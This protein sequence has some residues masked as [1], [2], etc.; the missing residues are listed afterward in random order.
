MIDTLWHHPKRLEWMGGGADLP[1]LHS[2]CV[3][4]RDSKIVRVAVS[5]GGMWMTRDAGATWSNDNTGMWQDHAPEEHRMNPNGQDAHRMVQCPSRLTAYGSSITT[6]SS[7]PMTAVRCG[8]E[9]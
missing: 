1:G 2:I 5:T 7:A 8:S 9:S 3:D 4:P 6:A